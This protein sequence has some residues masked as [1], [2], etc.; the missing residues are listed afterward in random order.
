MLHPNDPFYRETN[1]PLFAQFQP[2]PKNG[3]PDEFMAIFLGVMCVA[4]AV[5]L[6]IAIF[7]L[8]TLSKALTRCRPANRTM[9]PGQVWLNLIPLFNIVW[10]F[11]TVA[12]VAESLKNEFYDRGW[13]DRGDFGKGVGT[14]YCIMNLLGFVPFIGGIFS[15]I[16]L[17]CFI[18][19]WVKVAGHSKELA[20]GGGGGDYD[21]DYDDRPKKRRKRDDYD[22]EDDYDR[23]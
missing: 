6:V 18:I 2:Q 13:D 3:P 21:D 11:I 17:V 8:L 7:F 16:G 23:R 14:T 22:D 10:Q 15:L 20:G 1:M 9:E 4:L 19:Y 12:R 5:G